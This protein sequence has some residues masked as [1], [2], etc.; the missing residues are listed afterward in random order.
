MVVFRRK[1]N[2]FLELI[3]QVLLACGIVVYEFCQRVIRLTLKIVYK[4]NQFSRWLMG[5]LKT[6]QQPTLCYLKLII[7]GASLN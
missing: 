2:I 1:P 3:N 6:G 5:F 4:R 7:G